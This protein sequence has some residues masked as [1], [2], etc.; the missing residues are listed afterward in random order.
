[1]V[2]R[3]AVII[4]TLI[5]CLA[6]AVIA[7]PRAKEEMSKVASETVRAVYIISAVYIPVFLG[8]TLIQVASEVYGRVIAVLAVIS[9]LTSCYFLVAT[10]SPKR[11]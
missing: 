11:Q 8:M 9:T 7:R 10:R 4:A 5:Y 1:M 6:I 2:D 3:I